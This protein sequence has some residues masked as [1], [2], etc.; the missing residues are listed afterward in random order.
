MESRK[1]TNY[2]IVH[3]S[4]TPSGSVQTFRDYHVNHNGWRDIGYHWVIGNGH[5]MPDGQIEPGRQELDSGAHCWGYNNCSIGI[6]IVGDTDVT[7]P[8]VSQYEMLVSKLVQLCQ[9]YMIPVKHIRGHRETVSGRTEGKTCPGKRVDMD[10]LRSEVANRLQ[11]AASNNT[12][13]LRLLRGM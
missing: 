7:P 9:K 10:K 8:T 1:E 11:E 4:A 3:C 5:G 2:I 13:Y 6:C 12:I